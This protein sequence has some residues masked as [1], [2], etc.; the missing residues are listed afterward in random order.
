MRA[1]RTLS[2]RDAALTRIE[3]RKMEREELQV[4]SKQNYAVTLRMS[5]HE[6]DFG[7]QGRDP[8]METLAI[9]M[10]ATGS[11][12]T[13][14]PALTVVMPSQGTGRGR[15]AVRR[16]YGR[17]T[18]MW[19]AGP[20]RAVAPEASDALAD[21][22]KFEERL[23]ELKG[24]YTRDREMGIWKQTLRVTRRGTASQPTG[25]GMSSGHVSPKN[26]SLSSSLVY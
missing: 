11:T 21:L 1:R 26:T 7:P 10:G 25:P 2:E 14:L 15:L 3:R 8:R 17:E 18:S 5:W 16:A 24:S 19:L 12:G 13:R 6:A 9:S 20:G 23:P 4:A 22:D